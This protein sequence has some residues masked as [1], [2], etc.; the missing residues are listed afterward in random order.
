MDTSGVTTSETSNS[1]VASTDS[2]TELALYLF[3]SMVS[4][5]F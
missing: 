4:S 5:I 3:D 2:V 1:E